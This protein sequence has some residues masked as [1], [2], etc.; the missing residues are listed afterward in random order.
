M[1]IRPF[2]H[3]D[4]DFVRSTAS[5]IGADVLGRTYSTWH[6]SFEDLA[7]CAWTAV[8]SETP[9]GFG[10]I[11]DYGDGLSILH[12]DVVDPDYQRRGVGTAL[13]LVRLA[14][15]D[16]SLASTIGLLCT[17]QS[18]SFYERFGFERDSDPIEDGSL[19]VTLTRLLRSF[20]E[21][22]SDSAWDNLKSAGIRVTLTDNSEQASAPDA[23][24]GLSF[25][26]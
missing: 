3:D 25:Q 12:S 16:E 20:S 1:T 21:R 26:R 8:I 9:I 24:P 22:L 17:D 23:S 18:I 11:E 19:G 7:S 2:A 14:T 4:I 10:A 15:L 13:V 5:R 6:E